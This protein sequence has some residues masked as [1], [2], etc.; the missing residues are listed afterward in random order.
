MFYI[1][2]QRR[3]KRVSLQKQHREPLQ[4]HAWHGWNKH[5]HRLDG[6]ASASVA[7]S[8]PHFTATDVCNDLS[9]NER[10][11]PLYSRATMYEVSIG[12]FST[13]KNAYITFYIRHV[14]CKCEKKSIALK[15]CLMVE[16]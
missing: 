13:L 1:F 8:E 2:I 14:T 5:K 3:R 4:K 10:E 9:I 16:K 12:G 15:F 11:R 6:S 7:V